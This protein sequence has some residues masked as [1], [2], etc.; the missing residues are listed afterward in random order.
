MEYFS[1]FLQIQRSQRQRKISH[2]LQV[3][4]LQMLSGTTVNLGETSLQM[5]YFLRGKRQRFFLQLLMLWIDWELGSGSA[6]ELVQVRIK[7]NIQLVQARKFIPFTHSFVRS[8]S[9]WFGWLVCFLV[10]LFA[11]SF[12]RSFVS[13]LQVCS[14]IT[15][16]FVASF[17]LSFIRQL[18]PS[19]L[20]LDYF[21]RSFARSHD[22]LLVHWWVGWLVRSFVRSRVRTSVQIILFVRSLALARTFV[23]LFIGW[24]VGSFSHLLVHSFVGLFSRGFPLVRLYVRSLLLQS[25]SLICLLCKLSLNRSFVNSFVRLL[26]FLIRFF[27]FFFSLFIAHS[28]VFSDSFPEPLYSHQYHKAQLFKSLFTS[29]NP[30]LFLLIFSHNKEHLQLLLL[31]PNFCICRL[32]Q[33]V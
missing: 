4:I 32:V 6:V 23:C 24:L 27:L 8:F 25:H 2:D 16:S 15:L 21:V 26:F 3:V 30:R 5:P 18:T 13:N 20:C 17:V 33:A 12:C 1:M 14:L 9:L 28:F 19:Y 31:Y 22:R 29:V 10:R 11:R 7:C